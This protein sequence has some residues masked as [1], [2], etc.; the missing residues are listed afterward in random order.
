MGYADA[1]GT[2]RVS[3]G[4]VTGTAGDSYFTTDL[5]GAMGSSGSPVFDAQ[6]LVIGMFSRTIIKGAGNQLEYGQV[7][8]VHVTSRL[9]AEGLGLDQNRLPSRPAPRRGD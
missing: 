8:R 1:D 3:A 6:G 9:V 4:R 2:L 7:E 5:D